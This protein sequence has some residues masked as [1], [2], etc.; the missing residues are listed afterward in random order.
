MTSD[1]SM[2]PRKSLFF[3]KGKS[4]KEG[5]I[6]GGVVTCDCEIAKEGLDCR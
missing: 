4:V 1:I 6:D 2:I 5:E 3:E